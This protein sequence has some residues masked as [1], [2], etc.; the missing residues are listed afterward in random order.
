MHEARRDVRGDAIM[1]VTFVADSTF[2]FEHASIR[3]LTDPWIGTTIYGG[4]W[5]QFPPPVIKPSEVGRLDYI[6]ISHI[7]EDHCDPQTIAALDRNAVVLL[8]ERTPNF[9]EAFLRRHQFHFREVRKIP[10]F[11]KTPLTNDLAVEIIDAD[12]SHALNH[13]IDSALLL[14]WGGKTIHFANDDSPYPESYPHLKQYDFALSILPA[15]GGSGYPACFDSLSLEEQA[16]ERD[17]IVAMYFKTFAGAVNELR[18]RRILASAGNHVIVGRSAR[19]NNRMTFLSSPMA[20]YR[21]TYDH[22]DAETRRRV[23]PL[24]LHEGETWDADAPETQDPETVWAL[25]MKEGDRQDRKRRFL[26]DSMVQGAYD[27]DRMPVP[28]SLDWGKLFQEAGEALLRSTA[29]AKIDFKSNIYIGLPTKPTP[30]FGVINGS[31]RTIG[32]VDG[33]NPKAE[34]YL[35]VMTDDNLMYQLL[36][37]DFS[38]NIADAAGFLRYR[39]IPNVYDQEAVIALNYL[40]RPAER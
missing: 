1:E 24:N 3:L 4:A 15:S 26:D 25:A 22:L 35:E 38:W 37:G 13:L 28:A 31:K 12:P 5:R 6:F 33:V 27:H 30:S 2:I 10:P 7:H 32:I 8:M 9:V 23:M 19:L 16:R 34:P 11:K 36:R 40:R 29:D 20:A 14:H 21:Y 39:R 17:R 18:P